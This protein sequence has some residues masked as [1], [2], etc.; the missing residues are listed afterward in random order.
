MAHSTFRQ[1]LPENLAPDMATGYNYTNEYIEGGFMFQLPYPVGALSATATDM[2]RFMI[3]HLQNGELDG[4]RI[5]QEETALQMHSQLYTPDP[6]L[7]S[8]AHGFWENTENGQRL[9]FHGWPGCGATGAWAGAS[10]TACW[11]CWPCS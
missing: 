7:E 5:L 10:F 6:R 11:P 9:V 2:A 1:P 3:A 8:M 4:Q